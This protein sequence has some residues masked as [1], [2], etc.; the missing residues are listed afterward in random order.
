VGVGSGVDF[1]QLIDGDFC[2]DLSGVQ[3][4]V[5]KQ[6]LNETDVGSVVVHVGGTGVAE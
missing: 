5:A 3:S 4:S 6:L 2:V 1:E